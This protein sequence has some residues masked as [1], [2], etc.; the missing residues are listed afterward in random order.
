[1]EREDTLSALLEIFRVLR[2]GGRAVLQFPNLMYPKHLQTYLE[3][4]RRRRVQ[5]PNRIRYYTRAEVE[6]ILTG[7]GFTIEDWVRRELPSDLVPL[8][9][10]PEVQG[11]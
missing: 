2:P 5:H 6:G 3:F 9:R 11:S 10:K 4:S 7:I 8:V 1:M